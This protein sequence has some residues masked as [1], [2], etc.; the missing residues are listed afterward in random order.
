VQDANVEMLPSSHI[1]AQRLPVTSAKVLSQLKIHE[2][3]VI[4]HDYAVH[5]TVDRAFANNSVVI[6]E[7]PQQDWNLVSKSQVEW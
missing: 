7:L 3:G 1:L 6:L 2:G 5:N 4:L